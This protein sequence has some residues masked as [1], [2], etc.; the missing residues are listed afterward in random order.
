MGETLLVHG[1]NG[2]VGT[3]ALQIGVATGAQVFG[4]VRSEEAAALVRRAG[5]RAVRT[6][7]FSDDVPRRRDPRAGRRA[8]LSGQPDGA[9]PARAH[10][11][12]RRRCGLEGRARPRRDDGPP[13]R[14]AWHGAA[15]PVAGGQGARGARVRARG[16]AAPGRRAACARSSTG[17]IPPSR[18]ARR[19]TASPAPASRA[20]CWSTSASSGGRAPLAA[21]AARPERPHVVAHLLEHRVR[22][23]QLVRRQLLGEVPADAV[24]VDGGARRGGP[25][26]PSGVMSTST[27]RRSSGGRSRRTRPAS[28]I[29]SITR[30][31]PLLL[32]RMRLAISVI[33]TPPPASSRCTSTSY[34]RKESPRRPGARRRGCRAAPARTRRRR[35]TPPARRGEGLTEMFRCRIVRFAT[36]RFSSFAL[37]PMS[38][39]YHLGRRHRRGGGST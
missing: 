5:R 12:G 36:N 23:R 2:G 13:G 27:T 3:A 17:S 26:G 30:V 11:G 8:A 25:R 21:D 28:S 39:A 31:S 34:Q 22:A 35:A 9:Q 29:L 33:G 15:G 19:T 37:R 16:R 14:A 38:G 6:T 32:A 4:V 24:A 18:P 1:A 10:R 7:S 20:R